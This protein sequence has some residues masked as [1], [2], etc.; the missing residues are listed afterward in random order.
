MKI[1][2]RGIT[3]RNPR[4]T[5]PIPNISKSTVTSPVSVRTECRLTERSPRFACVAN[6]R[7][8]WPCINPNLSTP[9]DDDLLPV[10]RRPFML[11]HTSAFVP[12]SRGSRCPRPFG[13]W[14]RVRVAGPA[15]SYAT[16]KED[17]EEG[18][19][20]GR[21]GWRRSKGKKRNSHARGGGRER[22]RR[23]KK[24]PHCPGGSARIVGRR[25]CG[26]STN[27]KSSLS[28]A[29]RFPLCYP[30]RSSN[31]PVDHILPS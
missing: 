29:S 30:L 4:D 19:K 25:M 28:L 23:D 11:D 17:E 22:E 27:A 7:R 3:L 21:Q 12:L 1:S 24:E 18:R 26:P 6:E 9:G 5:D 2:T 31:H 10:R 13:P 14:P 16:R 8:A 15:N 20:E